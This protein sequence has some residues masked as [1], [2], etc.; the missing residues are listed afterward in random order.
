MPKREDDAA[1]AST[2]KTADSGNKEA[3]LATTSG[4]DDPAA[5]KNTQQTRMVPPNPPFKPSTGFGLALVLSAALTLLSTM[6]PYPPAHICW[7]MDEGVN[8]LSLELNAHGEGGGIVSLRDISGKAM[9]GLERGD[10][11]WGGDGGLAAER[12][13]ISL[14]TGDG[15]CAARGTCGA[16]RKAEGS[17]RAERERD[18]G[19]GGEFGRGDG[20]QKGR[21]GQKETKYSS[22]EPTRNSGKEGVREIE[23]RRGQTRRTVS[24][25]AEANLECDHALRADAG[26]ITVLPSLGYRSVWIIVTDSCFLAQKHFPHSCD[27]CSHM[28]ARSQSRLFGPFLTESRKIRFMLPLL[29]T[30]DFVFF[31]RF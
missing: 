3:M 10:E 20:P 27:C 8:R 18:V 25:Q 16:G 13:W 29:F 11:R 4:K 17:E 5:A 30:C 24:G 15:G 12:L 31:A 19:E 7:P 28:R 26:R 14:L 6:S 21:S 9:L 1:D 23:K 2:S 22:F